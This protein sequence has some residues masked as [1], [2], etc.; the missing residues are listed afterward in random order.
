MITKAQPVRGRYGVESAEKEKLIFGN[1]FKMA[2]SHVEK[3]FNIIS[4]YSVTVP[5]CN[6]AVKVSLRESDFPERV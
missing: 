2:K 4:A 3:K 5:H 6:V 1:Q